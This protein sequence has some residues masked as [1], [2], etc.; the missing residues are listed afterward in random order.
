MFLAF[1]KNFDQITNYYCKFFS[2]GNK[3]TRVTLRRFHIAGRHTSTHVLSPSYIV[4]GGEKEHHK[5]NNLHVFSHECTSCDD[6]DNFSQ[7]FE[8][9]K[10]MISMRQCFPVIGKRHHRCCFTRI[11]QPYAQFLKFKILFNLRCNQFRMTLTRYD[12]KFFMYMC[13]K[14]EPMCRVSQEKTR[15]VLT[16]RTFFWN[17]Q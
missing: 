1:S 6:S 4:S 13:T 2:P 15:N 16:S 7:S 12:F 14:F 8:S 11:A 17:L 5:K 10:R 3:G 9:I